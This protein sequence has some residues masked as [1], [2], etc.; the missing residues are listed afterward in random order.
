MDS[1]ILNNLNDEGD[2]E[3]KTLLDASAQTGPVAPDVETPGKA[4]AGTFGLGTLGEQAVTSRANA[5]DSLRGI[6]AFDDKAY[7]ILPNSTRQPLEQYIEHAYSAGD[8]SSIFADVHRFM[9]EP[10]PGCM[11][12]WA[13]KDSP[14]TWGFIRSE[15]YRPVE[16]HELADA[17]DLP[18]TSNEVGGKKWVQCYDVLLMEVNPR[19]VRELYEKHRAQAALKTASHEPFRNLKQQVEGESR[20]L[21]TA[22]MDVSVGR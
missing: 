22:S 9:A 14:R 5:R 21:A 1:N 19:A 3:N 6:N 15:R 2:G 13:A 17:C 18:V 16:S 11:Y 7:I 12:V 4:G 10:K 8:H 20:G